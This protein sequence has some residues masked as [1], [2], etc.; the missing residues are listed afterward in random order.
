M[1]YNLPHFKGQMTTLIY[2]YPVIAKI[3]I[4]R[5]ELN[6]Y[7]IYT[8]IKWVGTVYIFLYTALQ[9]IKCRLP[10]SNLY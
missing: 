10:Q 6:S 7:L 5:D 1:L 2:N 3:W 4:I 9:F 8:Y